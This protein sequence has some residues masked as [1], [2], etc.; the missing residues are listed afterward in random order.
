MMLQALSNIFKIPD[1]KRKMIFTLGM[2]AVYR[3]GAFVPTPGINGAA[4]NAFF[5]NM[6]RSNTGGSLFEIVNMF[7]GQAMSRMTIFALGIMPY[8]SASIILQLLTTVVPVL[9][10]LAKEGEAG[11]KKMIQYTRYGTVILSMIQSYF[12]ALWLRA[13]HCSG[14]FR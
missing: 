1:L 9:E 8:I 14:M 12:I 11:Q 5:E 10:R 6:A 4:L 7:T 3:I 2:I 13:R